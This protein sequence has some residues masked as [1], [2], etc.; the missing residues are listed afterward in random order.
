M[1]K[2]KIKSKQTRIN[3]IPLIDIIFLML[4]F[5]MLATNFSK[6]HQISFS[7]LKQKE[8]NNNVIDNKIMV[9]YLRDNKIIYQDKQLSTKDLEYNFFKKWNELTFERVVI[10]NDKKTKI[11][12]LIKLLDLLKTN[13]II[14]VSFSNDKE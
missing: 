5:F 2:L 7:V 10:L 1:L 6:N 14:N 4:V 9:I 13:K 8:I 3:I 11:Q 12:L